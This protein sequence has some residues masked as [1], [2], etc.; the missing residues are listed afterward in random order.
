MRRFWKRKH[1]SLIEELGLGDETLTSVFSGSLAW[2]AG[3][4]SKWISET[5]LWMNISS[6][7]LNHA[8]INPNILELLCGERDVYMCSPD[9]PHL[10]DSCMFIWILQTVTNKPVPGRWCRSDCNPST[11]DQRLF[12]DFVTR[13]EVIWQMGTRNSKSESCGI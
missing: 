13:L 9:S 5:Q 10:T 8:V 7:P 11:M 6:A 2:W 3:F 4:V 12:I 1:I